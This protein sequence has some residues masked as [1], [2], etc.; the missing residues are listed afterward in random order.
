MP[1]IVGLERGAAVSGR[2]TDDK[3]E[4]LAGV[5]VFALRTRGEATGYTDDQGRYRIHGLAEGEYLIG[6]ASEGEGVAGRHKGVTY[7][8]GGE[9]GRRAEPVELKP[10]EDRE[11]VD[12]QFAAHGTGSVHARLVGLDAGMQAEVALVAEGPGAAVVAG[13]RADGEGRFQLERVPAGEYRLLAWAPGT[14]TGYEQPPRGKTSRFGWSAIEVKEGETAALD[15]KMGLGVTVEASVAG[16][17]CEGTD[18]LTLRPEGEWFRHWA[19]EGV[20]VAG[21]WRWENM[22]SGAYRVEMPA[23]EAECLFK[24]A[25]VGENGVVARVVRLEGQARLALVV[26]RGSAVI[27]GRVG[28]VKTEERRVML[29]AEDERGFA[30][31]ALCDEDGGFRFEGLAAGKYAAIAYTKTGRV[32]QKE[33][34]V[35]RGERVSIELKSRGE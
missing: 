6:A 9:D 14:G 21:G 22:P 7:Y 34:A 20:K 10:S 23:L 24:G 4:A 31:E 33:L 18:S 8:P 27:E 12:L 26:E 19:F 32:N 35:E 5:R 30:A 2:V 13:A 15:V 28:G 16:A 1:V 17:G 11:G 29:F 3:G 25:R